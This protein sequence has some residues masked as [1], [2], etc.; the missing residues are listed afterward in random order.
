MMIPIQSK[1]FN[2]EYRFYLKFELTFQ[3][4]IWQIMH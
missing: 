2:V 3:K 4:G 1:K